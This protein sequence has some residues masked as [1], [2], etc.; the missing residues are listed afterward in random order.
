VQTNNPRKIR[1]LEHLGVV[2]T[3]RIPCLVRPG[4]FSED[5]LRTKGERMEHM[6]TG[7]WCYWDHGGEKDPPH[8]PLPIDTEKF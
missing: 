8:A 5:Y 3:D 2:V 4:E 1:I 6:F 7:E